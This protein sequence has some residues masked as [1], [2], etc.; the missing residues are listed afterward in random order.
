METSQKVEQ[1]CFYH[2]RPFQSPISISD[3]SKIRL[4]LLLLFGKI[5]APENQV[6][7]HWAAK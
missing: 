4:L 3:K 5:S 6:V 7:G 1:E 2:F